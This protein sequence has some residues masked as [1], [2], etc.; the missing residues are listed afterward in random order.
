MQIDGIHHAG[1]SV[2]DFDASVAWWQRHFGFALLKAWD[3]PG[4]R[5]GLLGRDGMYLELFAQ[6]QAAP[7]PDETRTVT[8]SFGQRGWKHLALKVP[9]L[10]AAIE[11]LRAAGVTVLTEPVR[12]APPGYHYAFLR[13]PDGNHVELIEL[14]T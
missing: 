10:A 13:D 11:T 8:E 12:D 5:I 14:S 2:S 6:E 1:L 3:V 4:L 9:D 7:G